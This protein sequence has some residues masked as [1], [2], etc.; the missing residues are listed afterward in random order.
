MTPDISEAEALED[1]HLGHDKDWEDTKDIK[2]DM[3]VLSDEEIKAINERVLKEHGLN[4]NRTLEDILRLGDDARL[5]I[6]EQQGKARLEAQHDADLAWFNAQEEPH[7]VTVPEI[8][9]KAR[10]KVADEIFG[11]IEEVLLTTKDGYR[12]LEEKF[13]QSLKN[14]YG[15]KK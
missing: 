7:Y 6:I 15:V 2:G 14:K 12:M 1:W 13:W 4:P 11:E 10:Q 9:V 3:P 5:L 8:V